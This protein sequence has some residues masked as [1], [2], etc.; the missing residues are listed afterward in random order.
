M[1]QEDFTAAITIC[2]LHHSTELIINQCSENGQV[3]DFKNPTLRIKN[4]VPAVVSKLMAMGFSLSM[5][6]GLMSVEK[7]I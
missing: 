5:R 6:N 1:R 4:C 3:P 2:T 7:H